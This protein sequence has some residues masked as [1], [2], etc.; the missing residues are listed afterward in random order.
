MEFY[1]Q[2]SR[3]E[4]ICKCCKREVRCSKKQ[5][6]NSSKPTA[7]PVALQRDEATRAASQKPR[8]YEELGFTKEEFLEVVEF[9]KELLRLDQKGR[10]P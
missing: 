4:S 3:R 5:I 8:T 1:K 6:A 9:F 2:G 7:L 10:T